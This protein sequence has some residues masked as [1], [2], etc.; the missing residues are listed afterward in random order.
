MDSR[1][2]VARLIDEMA[3]GSRLLH[4]LSQI[5][6]VADAVSNGAFHVLKIITL[7]EPTHAAEVASVMGIGTAA[8]SR[9]L[10]ELEMAGLVAKHACADDGRRVILASTEAGRKALAGRQ[11]HRAR[12]LA[13]A[14]PD[15]TPQQ[16]DALGRS[17]GELND[18]MRRAIEDHRAHTAEEGR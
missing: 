2:P 12:R 15:W 17:L 3:R 18:A 13:D 9:H 11:A 16:I 1:T 14:L 8:V 7:K 4:V 10:A 6:A 5:E